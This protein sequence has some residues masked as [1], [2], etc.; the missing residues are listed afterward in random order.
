MEITCVYSS[1]RVGSI[2]NRIGFPRKNG[3]PPA[4]KLFHPYAEDVVQGSACL[5]RPL[6]IDRE[7]QSADGAA[8]GLRTLS[9]VLCRA[10]LDA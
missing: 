3:M 6:S 1:Y 10:L 2:T 5:R 4:K 7:R 9:A 8:R